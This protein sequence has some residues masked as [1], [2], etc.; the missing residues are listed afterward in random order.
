MDADLVLIPFGHWVNN[1]IEDDF[2]SIINNF[3]ENGGG[4]IY[5]GYNYHD[6]GVFDGSEP[7]TSW[8][9]GTNVNTADFNSEHPI[10]EGV[11]DEANIYAFGVRLY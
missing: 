7:W 9:C 6:Y 1:Y 5:T 4:V 10:M 11:G 3:A 2:K 8:C